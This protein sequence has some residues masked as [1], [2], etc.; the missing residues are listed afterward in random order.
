MSCF[1]FEFV[2]RGQNQWQTEGDG[3]TPNFFLA[4]P[5]F[6]GFD[7]GKYYYEILMILI[8]CERWMYEA[9]GTARNDL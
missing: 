9:G 7:G 3:W 8:K 6:D 5:T 1:E 2:W 4:A